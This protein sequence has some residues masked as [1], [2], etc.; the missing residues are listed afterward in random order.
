[1]SGI[2]KVTGEKRLQL[3]F[4]V[5]EERVNSEIQDDHDTVK[6]DIY[7]LIQQAATSEGLINMRVNLNQSKVF[8]IFV[9]YCLVN[10]TTSLNWRYKSYNTK[11][12][13]IFTESDESLC[14]LIL[15]NNAD[16]FLKVYTTGNIVTRKESKTKYTK[17]KGSVN[18]KFKGWNRNG[19]K[20]FNLLVRTVKK[21]RSLACSL[22]LEMKLK[23]KYEGI[24]KDSN[25][26]NI[27]GNESDNEDDTSDEDV[28]AYDGFAGDDLFADAMNETIATQCTNITG[29]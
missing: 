12:S 6:E 4:G 11:I 19:I 25:H 16:D 28:D 8:D 9:N 7:Q 22:E 27:L 18:A 20:R 1:M 29:V 17:S 26:S 13:D 21:N 15:E 14:M 10:F 2:V 23:Q 3:S 5:E 24:F